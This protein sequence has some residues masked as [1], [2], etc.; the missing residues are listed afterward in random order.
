MSEAPPRNSALV[1][2]V[3]KT[4][5]LLELPTPDQV[6]AVWITTSRKIHIRWIRFSLIPSE[7]AM[8]SELIVDS[9]E[10][11]SMQVMGDL[12]FLDGPNENSTRWPRRWDRVHPLT[13]DALPF[14]GRAIWSPFNP[15]CR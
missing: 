1:N 10:E 15:Y 2:V 9:P 5:S 13:L 6:I 4:C 7:L 8:T 14:N 3:D 12:C 11:V